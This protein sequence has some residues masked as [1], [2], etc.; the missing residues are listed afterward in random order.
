MTNSVT[1]IQAHY[2]HMDAE[3]AFYNRVDEYLFA[4]QGLHASKRF[5]PQRMDMVRTAIQ[6]TFKDLGTGT[7]PEQGYGGWEDAAKVN[8]GRSVNAAANLW[9]LREPEK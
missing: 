8:D 9:K 3:A 7:T 2:S 6:Q 5:G 4:I 1:T